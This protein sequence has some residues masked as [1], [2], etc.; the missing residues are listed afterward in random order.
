MLWAGIIY[1]FELQSAAHIAIVMLFI[2]DGLVGVAHAVG[3]DEFSQN[4]LFQKFRVKFFAYSV[5]VLCGFAVDLAITKGPT[6]FGFHYLS[7]VF[8]ALTDAAS[9][10]KH[11]EAFGIRVPFKNKI[12]EMLTNMYNR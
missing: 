3:R 7:C 12:Q 5:L 11:L 4:K 1:I 2:L 8:L 10:S 9:V 6:E